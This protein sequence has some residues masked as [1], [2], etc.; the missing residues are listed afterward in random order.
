MPKDVTIAVDV[1]KARMGVAFT[2]ANSDLVLPLATFVRATCPQFVFE[3]TAQ[4]LERSIAFEQIGVIYVGLPLS[5]SGLRT[6]STED[7]V[8]FASQLSELSN[9]NLRLIDERFSTNLANQILRE[10]HRSQKGSRQ[11]IDQLAAIEILN[12]ANAIFA[13]T[14]SLAGSKVDDWIE[15]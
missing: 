10:N 11:V 2:G 5:L 12:H 3:L 15:A 7:S 4:L 13:R 9:C 14:G 8:D 6:A 1:G